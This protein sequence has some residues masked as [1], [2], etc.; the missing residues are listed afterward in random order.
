MEKILNGYSVEYLP[1]SAE[2]SYHWQSSYCRLVPVNIF[3]FMVR[4]DTRKTTQISR[5]PKTF[6]KTTSDGGIRP[7]LPVYTREREETQ[8]CCIMDN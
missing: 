7:L 6:S 8:H 5:S 4:L 3:S 1:F 2:Q